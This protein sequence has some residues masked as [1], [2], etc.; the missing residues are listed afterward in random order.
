[1][2]GGAA[3]RQR[4]V[5]V[6]TCLDVKLKVTLGP[7]H[8][9]KPL[10]EALLHPYLK[11]FARKRGTEWERLRIEAV[12]VGGEQTLTLAECEAPAAGLLL[13]DTL[14]VEIVLDPESTTSVYAGVDAA[15]ASTLASCGLDEDVAAKIKQRAKTSANFPVDAGAVLPEAIEDAIQAGKIKTVEK[16][17]TS[18]DGHGDALRDDYQEWGPER[19]GGC[20]INGKRL[21]DEPGYY[22]KPPTIMGTYIPA[23]NI[24]SLHGDLRM[25]QLFL[26]HGAKVNRTD[27]SGGTG[28]QGSTA[29]HYAA[30][31][32]ATPVAKMLI[33]AGANVN[34]PTEKGHATPLMEAAKVGYGDW[35]PRFTGDQ[36]G[37]L[38]STLLE[39]KA[40]PTLINGAGQT[41]REI[42]IKSRADTVQMV[43]N[44]PFAAPGASNSVTT[45]TGFAK[46]IRLLEEAEKAWKAQ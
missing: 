9:V 13:A 14:D 17:L 34:A 46:A 35:P 28:A 31:A 40:D 22:D 39:A 12:C 20:L 6:V 24:A 41:A 30:F 32:C 27:W 45:W 10:T 38:I 15:I 26:K 21:D 8:L 16:W 23:L 2:V 37:E 42:V 29:L 3:S 4:V 36:L 5:A 44:H 19:M 1:M 33:E 18:D 7:Q 11:A 43:R 25:A